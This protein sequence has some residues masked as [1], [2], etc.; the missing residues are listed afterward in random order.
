MTT[1]QTIALI[2]ALGGGAALRE[3]TVGLY[4][5][6]TGGQARERSALRQA[7]TDLDHEASWRRRTAEHAH[8]LRRMLLDRGVPSDE[9]PDFP[10]RTSIDPKEPS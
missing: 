2:I 7:M 8:E 1:D 9:L 3:I 5:W 10:A 4:R 6:I